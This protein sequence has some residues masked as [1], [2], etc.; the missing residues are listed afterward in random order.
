MLTKCALYDLNTDECGGS[1]DW[2]VNLSAF[3]VLFSET[4]F[5]F[6]LFVCLPVA[7]VLAFTA[8]SQLFVQ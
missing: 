3:S 7:H 8:P 1:F 6:L 4:R 5:N 2:E